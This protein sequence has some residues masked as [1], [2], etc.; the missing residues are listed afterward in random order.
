MQTVFP[1]VQMRNNEARIN[2]WVEAGE[3]G[4]FLLI[5]LVP[6]GAVEERRISGGE[7]KEIEALKFKNFQE[8]C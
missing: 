7:N 2:A 5:K 6:H 8:I 1:H 3:V 4:A